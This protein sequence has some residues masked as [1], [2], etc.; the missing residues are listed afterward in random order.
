MGVLTNIIMTK[1]QQTLVYISLHPRGIFE[2]SGGINQYMDGDVV[3]GTG[4][5]HP[6]A[7]LYNMTQQEREKVLNTL[8]GYKAIER[9]SAK[10][11]VTPQGLKFITKMKKQYKTQGWV[12][13]SFKHHY[14]GFGYVRTTN[15][16]Q[17][18]TMEEAVEWRHFNNFTTGTWAYSDFKLMH[19]DEK[20]FNR[21]LLKY[22][23]RSRMKELNENK[24]WKED[25]LSLTLALKVTEMPNF[26]KVDINPKVAE[27]V[28]RKHEI[29]KRKK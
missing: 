6:D 17:A 24:K 28:K 27:Y 9:K 11:F 13:L 8:L 26:G 4:L 16:L 2:G 19:G 7:P 20:K 18:K 29:L 23:A 21:Y 5:R 25:M 1:E 22:K 10:Y 3:V 12:L 14:K 15:H